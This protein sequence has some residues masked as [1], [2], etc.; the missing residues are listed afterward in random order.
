MR[1]TAMAIGAGMA[2]ASVAPAQAAWKSY[3]SHPFGFS[4][5]APG[6]IKLEKGTYQAT[7]AGNRETVVYRSIEDNIEYKA[8]VIDLT[9]QE[10]NA[11][12]LL[13]EATFVFMNGKKLLMDTFGRVDRQYGRKITID[14]PNNGGRS[15]GAFYFIRGRLIHLE[16]TVLPANGDYD[17]PDMARFVDSIAFF[18]VRA[19]PD[20]TELPPAK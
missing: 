4:F 10:N 14:R 5:E 3:I 12:T 11:A 19:A 13:N 1:G 18:T 2:L 9:A 6:E 16:A 7:I 8:S 17:S 15:M 20:A